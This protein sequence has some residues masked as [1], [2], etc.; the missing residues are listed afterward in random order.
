MTPAILF[1]TYL[2]G[3]LEG[4]QAYLAYPSLQ[5]C[6]DATRAVSDTVA[7]D[8]TINCIE[9]DMV[10]SPRPRRNQIYGEPK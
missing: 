8:H 6:Y 4:G 9:G 10:S 3:P 1:I 5:A 2:S 7:W